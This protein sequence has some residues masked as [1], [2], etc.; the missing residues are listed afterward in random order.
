MSHKL[1]KKSLL[2]FKNLPLIVLIFSLF[3]GFLSTTVSQN[4][5]LQAYAGGPLSSSSSSVDS[6]QNVSSS[7]ES[8]MGVSSSND[9]SETFSSSESS[10]QAVSSS[11]DSSDFSSSSQA[12]SQQ[13][14]SSLTT[15]PE[16]EELKISSEF[17]EPLD[18]TLNHDKSKDRLN[19]VFYYTD[20]TG[21]LDD[22]KNQVSKF[23]LL[24]DSKNVD[25]TTYGV[26]NIE[27]FKSN[28]NKFNFWF[29]NKA[30]PSDQDYIFETLVKTTDYLGIDYVTAVR[31]TY[32][33]NARSNADYADISY[34]SDYSIK[35][36]LNGG[37]RLYI[38]SL[39]DNGI[40]LAHEFAHSIFALADE[41]SEIGND[42]PR[43]KYPNCAPDKATA[44]EWW[45]DLEGSIDP[46]FYEYRQALIDYYANSENPDYL[47]YNDGVLE[48]VDYNIDEN[49][50]NQ[51]DG[52]WEL[53][54]KKLEDLNIVLNEED[55]RVGFVDGLCF[56]TSPDG[57]VR[58]TI[59]SAMLT[60][61]N[62]VYGSVNRRK[63]EK[64]LDMFSG[65]NEKIAKRKPDYLNPEIFDVY[66]LSDT[67]CV[68]KITSQN[69]KLLTCT[70]K[71]GKPLISK[72]NIYK[73]GLVKYD[74]TELANMTQ[75]GAQPCKLSN[76]GALF[77]CDTLDITDKPVNDKY[78]LLFFFEPGLDSLDPDAKYPTALPITKDQDWIYDFYL[79][80]F[81][82]NSQTPQNSSSSTNSSSSF[83]SAKNKKT[84][85]PVTSSIIS[86][87]NTQ[88]ATLPSSTNNLS[89][90]KSSSSES[91]ISSN[92]STNKLSSTSSSNP[93][94][95]DSSSSQSSESK[96]NNFNG[97]VRNILFGVAGLTVLVFV[98]YLIILKSKHG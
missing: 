83:E 3:T 69:K 18:T 77:T 26:F 41:Y 80:I 8:S 30:I 67:N 94:N 89:S 42:F 54:W 19:I 74:E 47:R 93:S 16:Y 7:A 72:N 20:Y 23:V 66:K 58:P 60:R 98:G 25:P 10:S 4:N 97:T 87:N 85:I 84:A 90:S 29:Y 86:N 35:T 38:N 15:Y 53:S 78:S 12:S 48:I 70:I 46:F 14:S 51:W 59:T 24:K 92:S 9:S 43:I 45:G 81:P 65:Q 52:N 21:S 57:V 33:E 2:S 50:E 76:D 95:T 6:S 64:I 27:P 91:S 82:V 1:L 56:S 36:Y 73:I 71:N 13:Q 49:I 55:F 61:D 40:V 88:T 5:P 75:S 17:L 28:I 11:N 34:N 63:M 62:A 68:V 44:M 32:D 96:S 31:L 37:V 39:R 79:S 22:L